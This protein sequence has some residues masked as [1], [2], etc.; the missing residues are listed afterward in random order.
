MATI[1]LETSFISACVSTRLDAASRRRRKVSLEWWQTT[2]LGHQEFISDAVLTELGHPLYPHSERALAFVEGTPVLTITA[3]M[4]SLAE[5]LIKR[6]AMPQSLTGDALHVAMATV[7]G[8]EY[9]LTW[10][11]K[12][13]ANP[14]KARHVHGICS[15]FGYIAPRIIRPDQFPEEP[16]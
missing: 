5:A 15:E 12:H 14:N 13:L 10:N 1:Y 3:S 4:V 9:I 6:K 16:R 8:M 11:V 7:S 2:K